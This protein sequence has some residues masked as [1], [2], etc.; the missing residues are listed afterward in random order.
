MTF[1]A[2]SRQV[3]DQI[4]GNHSVAKLMHKINHQMVL[5]YLI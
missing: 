1:I 3:F 4:H 5:K 2:T